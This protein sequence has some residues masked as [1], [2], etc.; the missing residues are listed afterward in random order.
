MTTTSLSSPGPR[1]V[2]VIGSGIIG[3]C[4]AIDLAEAGLAV[5]LYDRDDLR[6][7]EG[8]GASA[9]HAGHV[10][11]SEIHPL[12]EP[13]LL[14]K[15]P[16]L[17]LDPKG[18]LHVR[19]AYL[20]KALPWFLRV[21]A[22]CRPSAYRTGTAGLQ[23]L[24]G[25]VWPT[26]RGLFQRS[27]LAATLQETGGLFL[28]ETDRE[29]AKAAPHWQALRATG[30]DVRVLGPA[31]IGDLEPDLAPVFPKAVFDPSWGQVTE[32]LPVLRGLIAYG[33][34]LGVRL[35]HTEIIGLSPTERT[36]T[37]HTRDGQHVEED[38][39]VVAAGAWSKRLTDQIGD[40]IPLDSERGHNATLPHAGTTLRHPL[41]FKSRG[42]VATQLNSG[43]RIG[44]WDEFAGPD[45]PPNH[46]LTQRILAIS[47]RF[48]PNLNTEPR[49]SWMGPRPS[50]PDSR[51]IIGPSRQ[52]PR[53]VYAFG[54][55]HLG[56]TQA[57][58]T[59][60]LVRDLIT[61]RSPAIDLAPFSA[62]RFG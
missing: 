31:E 23:A 57:P 26:M 37:V 15:A 58:A 11:A 56:F 54:H 8:R 3:I 59:G 5:T 44:G 4:C 55:G 50:L 39:I 13:G 33:A 36:V 10:A 52:T 22:A 25:M 40:R 17:L 9:N 34:G 14:L 28:Y 47:A 12:A 16:R 29:F 60:A 62:A 51:P 43:L 45:A 27:G 46:R 61:G 2:G 24:S 41:V 1:T 53:V 20:A 6:E 38:A 30:S 18:P 32:T 49:I 42:F 21:A 7:V 19:P 35:N 48:F